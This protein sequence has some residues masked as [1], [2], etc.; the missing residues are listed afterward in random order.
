M[1]GEKKFSAK[2]GSGVIAECRVC[3]EQL[4]FW[5]LSLVPTHQCVPDF[6]V[7]TV[8]VQ[9]SCYARSAVM[10]IHSGAFR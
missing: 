2:Y 1:V 10:G 8:N 7:L 4:G 6:A 3:S 9:I 5:H